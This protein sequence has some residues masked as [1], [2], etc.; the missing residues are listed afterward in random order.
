MNTPTERLVATLARYK[1]IGQAPAFLQA[2]E[3]LPVMAASGATVLIRGETGTGKELV[4]RAVHYLS[5]RAGG[6]FVAVNCGSLPDTLLEAELFGH[7]R[8]AFTDAHL[9]R[10]GLVAEAEQGTLFLDE[11]NSLS[12]RGQVCLLRLLQE[13]RYRA[14]GGNEER[15]ADV[16]VVVASNAELESLVAGERF[17]AD[18]YYRLCVFCLDLPPLRE[19]REDVP[20]LA[21]HLLRKHTP[22][23]HA[24]PSLSAAAADALLAHPWP[25]NV[26]ELENTMLRAVHLCQGAV[27]EPEHLGRLGARAPA[28]SPE[29]YR[30]GKAQAVAAFESTYLARL[31]ASQGGNITR[32]AA[33]AHKDR[34]DLSR[35]LHKH[36]IDPGA[37]RG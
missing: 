3:A 31:M 11:V 30:A 15:A 34:R 13:R 33:V 20:L 36:G 26:R 4:A 18:L 21:A 22:A 2:V 37:F 24:T 14:L 9:R 17:R 29:T 12:P 8:G 6:P 7:E 27:V 32:A 1:L 19:R 23:G 35:L 25:G 16:R 10:P 28:A 5:T